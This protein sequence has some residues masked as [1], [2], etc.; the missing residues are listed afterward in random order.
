MQTNMMILKITRVSIAIIFLLNLTCF[1]FS[2][3]C[4]A[5][6]VSSPV[7]Q[8]LSFT[9]SG[10][11]LTTGSQTV[12]V[13]VTVQDD[14]G[15]DYIYVR[16]K[17]P[18]GSI[19]KENFFYPKT[20]FAN[21]S[22]DISVFE[23]S[24]EG[25][26]SIEYVTLR[27]TVGNTAN[28]YP[29]DIQALGFPVG[30]N[31]INPNADISPPVLQSLSLTPSGLDL[32]TGSQTVTVDVTVQDETGVDYIYVR[33]K[34]PSGNVWKANSFY[35]KTSPAS[36][37][38][39]ISV[40]EQSAEGMYSIEYIILRDTV[41]NTTSYYPSDIQA[42]GFPASFN[43]I[44]PNADASPPVLQ[45]LSFTP[46]EVDLTTGSQTVTV[47]V[48]VQ[49]EIGVDYIYV[50]LKNPSGNVWK[51]NSFY[52]KTPSVSV[53]WDIAMFEQSVE[54]MYSIE[55]ITLRDTVGNTTSYYPTDIQALGFSAGFNVFL[56]N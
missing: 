49:D 36:V 30:F 15:V 50:R 45:N 55:Y 4:F 12:T 32:T 40:F 2:E 7:L 22:W 8:D 11:D 53:A 14:T 25:M 34:N 19:W 17:N 28:Y 41:G 5:G 10:V 43:V 16:L 20:S 39:D 46:F 3:D 26:Y 56:N 13:D 21:V 18:S 33:L 24:A 35:P 54:G 31:V 48:T 37:T 9:P 51:A 27:D 29:T 47:D 42:L 6:D 52:P 44:N 38:W 23:Q 1:D